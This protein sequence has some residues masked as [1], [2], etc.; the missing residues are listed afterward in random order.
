MSTQPIKANLKDEE[1]FH[2]CESSCYVEEVQ[3][4]NRTI[5]ISFSSETTEIIRNFGTD[6][7][8]EILPEILL[9]NYT[10]ID[11]S[12]INSGLVCALFNHDRSIIIG[13]ISNPIIDE[14]NGKSYAFVTFDRDEESE[15]YFKKT[16]SGSLR[17]VSVGY[18][19]FE[20]ETVKTGAMS[21]DGKFQGPCKIA[22][23]WMPFEVS[24]LAIPADITVGVNRE[25]NTTE[26]IPGTAGEDN[27]KKEPFKMD[28]IKTEVP[29][30]DADQIR[31]AEQTRCQEI[32][33]LC[34]RTGMD[35]NVYIADN[36]TV[37][38]V[39]TLALEKLMVDNK[40]TDAH[41]ETAVITNDQVDKF[42]RAA[43][44]AMA[45][46]YG[47]KLAD[48][49]RAA[50]GADRLRGMPIRQLMAEY[51]RMTGVQ[52]AHSL[53]EK[54][55]AKRALTP[56]SNFLAV[57]DNTLNKSMMNAAEAVGTTYQAWTGEMTVNDF[58]AVNM[59]RMSEAGA[60]E[61]VQENGEL[62]YTTAV[63]DEK[64]S[65]SVDTYGRMFGFTRQMIINDDMSYFIKIPAAYARAAYRQINATVY[66][67][68]TSNAAIY[69]GQVLFDNAA[70][71][72]NAIT[73]SGGVPSI[74]SFNAMATFMGSQKDISGT[75]YLN[76]MPKFF[77]SGFGASYTGKQIIN[78]SADP[79]ASG[80]AAVNN[81]WYGQMT[82]IVDAAITSTTAWYTACDPNINETVVV[83]YL[84][85][86]NRPTIEQV[87]A[88]GEILGTAFRIYF[89]WGATV[90]DY[91]G[92]YYN[93]G[94]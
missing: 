38:A 36:S 66:G 88:G 11:L 67:L 60:L 42:C 50:D 35:A 87:D 82:P 48:G 86:V 89:D 78:S 62:K 94:T 81:P 25:M 29:A 85:G 79:T 72:K 34:Q 57:V 39:R 47:V 18:R 30:V 70:T 21:K 10:A 83:G 37:D 1:I 26:S 56:A 58:K 46:R 43:G 8:P 91:R 15:K 74:S 24:L 2:R 6:E 59:Y 65:M 84:N 63:S 32:T 33:A 14:A 20:Y 23:R 17:G 75:A 7:K 52:D 51:L 68:L 92:L 49:V 31:K 22:I 3:E 76:L 64:V 28:E 73:S 53:S 90:A 12:R 77:I 40:P 16:I 69:D 93:V 44:D 27:T 45:L 55:L 41:R 80:N 4:E 71:H 13:T 19:V 61:K 9:N 5:K 54:E